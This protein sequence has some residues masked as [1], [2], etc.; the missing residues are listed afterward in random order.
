MWMAGLAA[1]E[2]VRG[3]LKTDRVTDPPPKRCPKI[4]IVMTMTKM[5]MIIVIKMMMII[6]IKMM[7]I[8][9]ILK[10]L[11]TDRVTSPAPKRC[12]K[13][14]ISMTM[15]KMI[16]MM[17]MKNDNNYK[18]TKP[19]PSRTTTTTATARTE[20]EQEKRHQEPNNLRK[21]AHW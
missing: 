4:W 9:M 3:Q 11:K 19:P 14:Q 10:Q 2:T 16:N 12:P 6:V 13:I 15:T 7:M 18:T 1:G 8:M 5:M 20:Q 17:M 21:L